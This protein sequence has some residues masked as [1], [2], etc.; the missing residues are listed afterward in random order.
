MKAQRHLGALELLYVRYVIA[1]IRAQISLTHP[2][3]KW[4]HSTRRICTHPFADWCEDCPNPMRLPDHGKKS[5]ISAGKLLNADSPDPNKFLHALK[6][7]NDWRNLHI[8]PMGVVGTDLR[9][10]CAEV[11]SR[12]FTSERIK[13]LESISAKLERP[14]LQGLNL[15][16]MQ[17]I[18]GCRAILPDVFGVRKV[19]ALYS[20]GPFIPY[21]RKDYIAEP[22]PSGYRG[23]H[24]ICR[25]ASDDPC[26]DG[27]FI[28]IQLR[29]RY[30]HIIA[31]AVET[32]G[33]FTKQ[34]FKIQLWR[35]SM[36]S[37]L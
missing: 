8:K 5:I 11:D 24:L 37:I 3:P 15:W 14:E 1:Q 30:Q 23:I 31:T 7:A 13:R 12:A 17:D 6:I 2:P 34:A 27:M 19:E 20:D 4:E 18:G 28:E 29:S 22:P 36:A 32:V 35:G 16:T 21:R 33:Y 25:Y 26:L 9:K 10:K